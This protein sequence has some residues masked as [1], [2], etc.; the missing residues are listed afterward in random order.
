[1][2]VRAFNV[3]TGDVKIGDVK[4]GDVGT[5]ENLKLKVWS[6]EGASC[7]ARPKMPGRL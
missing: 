7:A 2:E 4:I 3:E 1:M 6:S 5:F